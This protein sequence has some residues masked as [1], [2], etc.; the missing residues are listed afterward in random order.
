MIDNQPSLY[1][2]AMCFDEVDVKEKIKKTI[3]KK[4]VKILFA[5]MKNLHSGKPLD[6]KI[7]FTYDRRLHLQSIK[8]IK[9]KEDERLNKFY[10]EFLD[11]YTLDIFYLTLEFLDVIT[12]QIDVPEIFIEQPRHSNL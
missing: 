11:H 8:I 12:F 10:L 3:G 1:R 6:Q 4:L 7:F 9:H 5:D 2:L